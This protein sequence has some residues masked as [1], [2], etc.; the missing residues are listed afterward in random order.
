MAFPLSFET[1]RLLAERLLPQHVDDIHRMHQD[2][3]GMALLGG[4]RDA[5]QTAA[6]MEKNLRHW[7]QFG[8]GTWILRDRQDQRVAGRAVLRHLMVEGVDEIEVGYGFHPHQ[9]G[10]GLASEITVACLEFARNDLNATSVVA[11]THPKHERSQNV[12]IK[13]GMIYDREVEEEGK[14]HALF[15]TRSGW[16]RPRTSATG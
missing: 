10:R 1:E 6:Y 14:V 8:F 5:A 11:L 3:R 9:W 7:D 16:A 4:I 12:L 15:R 13:V 2:S